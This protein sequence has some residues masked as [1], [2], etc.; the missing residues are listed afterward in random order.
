[1]VFRSLFGNMLR[2]AAQR[3]LR[4]AR[5]EAGQTA[6]KLPAA[7]DVLV[8]M[9]L[10]IEAGGLVDCLRDVAVL[11]G[12]GFTE[13]F[14]R[15]GQSRLVEILETGPGEQR[16]A[17]AISET[18]A[19]RRPQWVISAGF[20]GGLHES[21]RRG[22]FLMADAVTSAAHGGEL[23]IGL[24]MDKQALASAPQV[25]VG[26]LLTVDR[27]AGDPQEKRRLGEAHDALACDMETIALAQA[28]RQAKTRLLSVRIIS[29]AVDDA[30]PKEIS[31]L[32]EQETTAAQLGAAAAALWNRPSAAKDLWKLKQDALQASDRLAKF[33]VGV[34]EQLPLE[35]PAKSAT[36]E[37]ASES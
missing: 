10:S 3:K 14:G 8:V 13:R 7:C 6:A 34:I 26:R 35:S 16:A 1:M 30:L 11:A 28:C 36:P 19:R 18:L 4:E 25:H 32:L 33:L 21:L 24:T 2:D 9:A 17:G 23:S 5:E 31:K 12:R 27:I 29:D 20:A 15:L 37:G 22:H